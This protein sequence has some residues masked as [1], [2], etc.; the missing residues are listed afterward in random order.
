VGVRPPTVQAIP[1]VDMTAAARAPMMK[2][3]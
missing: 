2:H 3:G 1:A